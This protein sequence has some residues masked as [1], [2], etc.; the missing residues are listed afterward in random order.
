LPKQET[1]TSQVVGEIVKENLCLKTN[2]FC[3]QKLTHLFLKIKKI[4]SLGAGAG[5]GAA[6]PG[7]GGGGGGHL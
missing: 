4:P 5:P 7:E 6:R 3:L 1:R 2:F